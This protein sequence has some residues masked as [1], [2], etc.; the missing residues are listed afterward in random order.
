M[1]HQLTV[2]HSHSGISRGGVKTSTGDG[3][4]NREV[5]ILGSASD[6]LIALT[7]DVS[8]L[9]QVFIMATQDM[10]L[11]WNDSAGAQGAITLKANDPVGWHSDLDAVECPN[12]LL[13]TD[14]TAIYVTNDTADAGTF[15]MYCLLDSTV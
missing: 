4:C 8:Q 5:S 6:V 10:T 13:T 1:Q 12:P 14:I 9:K 15:Y 2:T 7:L 11:E 3:E